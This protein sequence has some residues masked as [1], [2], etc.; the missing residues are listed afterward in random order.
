MDNLL[1]LHRKFSKSTPDAITIEDKLSTDKRKIDD[2]F[3]KYFAT[4]CVTDQNVNQ[5]LP[6]YDEYL[7]NPTDASFNFEQV[8]NITVHCI[9]LYCI[10]L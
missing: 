1:L 8:E 9:V 2:A 10:V 5:N 3:N 6:L 4:A 7:N